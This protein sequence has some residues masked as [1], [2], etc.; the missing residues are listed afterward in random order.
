MWVVDVIKVEE[1][2]EPRATNGAN[3]VRDAYMGDGGIKELE[4]SAHCSR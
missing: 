3:A 1:V 2:E 4:E